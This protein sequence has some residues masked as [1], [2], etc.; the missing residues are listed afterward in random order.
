[1][2][3]Q[4]QVRRA[5]EK[6]LTFAGASKL[7][8]L[9]PASRFRSLAVALLL[10]DT[11]RKTYYY[12]LDIDDINLFHFLTGLINGLA[13][14]HA[15]F[16]RHLNVL[17]QNVL[18]DPYRHVDLVLK[19]FLDEL[20][21]FGDGDFILLLDEFDRADPA[22]DIH[23]FVERL[24]HLAPERCT[25]VLNGRSLPRLPWLSMMAKRHAV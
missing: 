8:L 21:D 12:A 9:H 18:Q 22:D 20:A 11:R 1:M 25:I 17:P 16:G 2:N 6:F 14:Q 3:S 10:A 23:R 5:Y 7:V 19:T 15:S 24:S 13:K 4:L